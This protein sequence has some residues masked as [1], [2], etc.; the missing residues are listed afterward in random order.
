MRRALEA[1]RQEHRREALDLSD[2]VVQGLAAARQAL[3]RNE[4]RHASATIE[5]T[6]E[7]AR[8]VVTELLADLAAGSESIAPGDLVRARPAALDSTEDDD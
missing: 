2:T 1:E 3:E 7:T 4:A 8:K 5:K 6:L